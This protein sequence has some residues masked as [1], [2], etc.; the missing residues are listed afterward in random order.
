[1]VVVE[2]PRRRAGAIELG[3]LLLVS[4]TAVV[5]VGVFRGGHG[6]RDRSVVNIV[7]DPLSATVT[8]DGVTLTMT[9]EHPVVVAGDRVHVDIA[10]HNGRATPVAW[11]SDGC[12][13]PFTGGV[14]LPTPEQIGW[15]GD[16]ASLA[17][18]IDASGAT[19]ATDLRDIRF[20][21]I[22]VLDCTSA[23]VRHDV[24]PGADLRERA[25][26]D[27]RT[28]DEAFPNQTAALAA[29]FGSGLT[30]TLPIRVV[31]APSRRTSEAQAIA[32][33]TSDH[34]LTDFVAATR[35]I[36]SAAWHV[37]MAWWQGGW[38]LWVDPGSVPGT[39]YSLRMRF[40]PSTQ[41]VV[42]VRRVASGQVAGNDPDFEPAP[43]SE[44]DVLIP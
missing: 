35:A 44:S 41:K 14:D 18:T 21:G 1:M 24:A 12:E 22:R 43:G 17:S 30:V 31:D 5:A 40:D 4:V 33:F 3:A 26:V 8:A 2:D 38:E 23:V 13:I 6:A 37:D 28:G 42:D 25:V 36:P 27:L 10:L 34:R 19:P 7:G 15:D 16:V 9:L 32:A 20:G 39:R 11:Q 29:T